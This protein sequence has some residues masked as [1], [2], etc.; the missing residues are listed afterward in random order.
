MNQA[1][2]GIYRRDSRFVVAEVDA[3]R[4]CAVAPIPE[5]NR[6]AAG[7]RVAAGYGWQRYPDLYTANRERLDALSANLYPRARFLVA[8]GAPRFSQDGG[9]NPSAISPAYLRAKVAEKPARLP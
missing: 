4:L 7:R 8:I 3:E 9:L 5:L 2:L 1:Y 6:D